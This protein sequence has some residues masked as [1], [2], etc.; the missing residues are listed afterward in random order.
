MGGKKKHTRSDGARQLGEYLDEH[1][2]SL[3]AFAK[4]IGC[5][6]SMIGMLRSGA[7]TPS[8]PLATKIQAATS[9]EVLAA[10]WP[11]KPAVAKFLAAAS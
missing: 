10:S 1:G 9:N 2:L 3:R 8:V 6:K 11:W 4:T 5:S 7:A